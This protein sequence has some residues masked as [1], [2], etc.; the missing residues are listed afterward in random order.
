[1]APIAHEHFGEYNPNVC[2]YILFCFHFA[3][4]ELSINHV[5]PIIGG[6]ILTFLYLYISTDLGLSL[7]FHEINMK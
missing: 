6:D 5:I 1:M 3:M 7:I 4:T 2:G